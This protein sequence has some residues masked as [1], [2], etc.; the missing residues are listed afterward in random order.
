MNYNST[1]RTRVLKM[2]NTGGSQ[3]PF[4]DA[5]KHNFGRCDVS[6]NYQKHQWLPASHEAVG[7]GGGG[8]E[9]QR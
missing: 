3:K 9:G 7:N 2:R 6:V 8:Q 5:M 4:K 1:H